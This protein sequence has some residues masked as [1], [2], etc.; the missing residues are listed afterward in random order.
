MATR[1]DSFAASRWLD[2]MAQVVESFG[3]E[4]HWLKLYVGE[5]IRLEWMGVAVVIVECRSMIFDAMMTE[6]LFKDECTV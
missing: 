1:I 3:F 5:C 2:Q 4:R 6:L